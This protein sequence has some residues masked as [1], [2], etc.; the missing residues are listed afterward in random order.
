MN[1]EE[2][3]RYKN[4]QN[5]CNMQKYMKYIIMYNIS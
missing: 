3:Q 4:T 2:F 5:A 1:L